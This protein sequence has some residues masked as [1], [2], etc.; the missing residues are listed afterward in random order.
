MEFTRI[1]A[2]ASVEAYLLHLREME[3]SQ[4]TIEQYDRHIRVFLTAVGEQSITKDAVLDFKQRIRSSYA[5]STVNT[6]LTAVNGFLTWLGLPG[7]RVKLLKC[8]RKMFRD[9]DRELTREEYQRLVNTAAGQGNTCLALLLET[10]CATGIRVSEVKYITV[11]AVRTGKTEISL[12]GKTRT[13]LIPGKLARK[14][15]KFARKKKITSGEIFLTRSGKS[16]DR[17]RIWAAM[18]QLCTRAGVDPHKVFPHNLRHLF[19]VT[20]YKACRDIA[21]LADVLGHSS[22]ETTRIYLTTSPNE[23]LRQMDRLG[24]VS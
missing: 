20:F 5:A 16:M 2:G 23:Q 3:R 4:G 13:I 15:R 22:V 21:R 24:L 10:I 9:P 11:E 7:C 6:M 12:K 19:A 17:K 14:L 1:T 18:K 8:Q